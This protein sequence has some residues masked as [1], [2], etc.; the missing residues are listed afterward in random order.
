MTAALLFGS[1]FLFAVLTLLASTSAMSA[2]RLTRSSIRMASS[3]KVTSYNV[4]SSQLAGENH[5]KAC[6]P[7]WL[8]AKYRLGVVKEKLESEVKD[9]AIICLQEISHDWTGAL[10]PFFAA[11][12]YHFVTGL[13]GNKFNGY[14]GCG[15]AV[16]N[17][18]YDI[19]DVD[20][21]RIADTKRQPRKD[22]PNFVQK[23][24]RDL[25]K[26]FMKFV[27]MIGLMKAKVDLWDNVLYR[28]NQMLCMRLKS[29]T[30]V[31]KP[32][33]VGTYH[34]PCMFKLPAVMVT[35]CALSAQHIQ[36]FA[37]A[38]PFIYTGDFNIKPDSSMYELM[39]KGKIEKNHPDYPE[40]VEGD[41]W[42]PDLSPPL[43][44]AYVTANGAEPDFTN[45]AKV[46]DQETFIETLDYLFYSPG[47]EVKSV[48]DLPPRGEVPGP[49]PNEAEPSDHI[50][51]SAEMSLLE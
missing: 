2:Q 6:K 36:R 28:S 48:K 19:V 12:G 49:L 37:K 11:H 8:N 1:F 35:H 15:I 20:I 3:I 38:D 5:F 47:W 26:T 31:R 44:S 42:A 51:I 32:F 21:T 24:L 9:K 18:K 45:Y 46:Q 43:K 14:M 34:M 10:H 30:G 41:T 29:K 22:K 7:E 25:Q 4:L 39:T 50:L 33:V 13:Y 40:N 27:I 17:D 16:P 23:L